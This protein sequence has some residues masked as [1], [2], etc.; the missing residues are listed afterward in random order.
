M[1]ARRLRWIVPAVL[2]LCACR[3][4]PP[5]AAP[6]APGAAPRRVVLLSLDGA[7]AGE[8]HRLY[9]AG[10]L[11]AGGFARFFREGQVADRLVP[12]DPSL[13]AVNHISLATGY[14]PGQTG[15]VGNHFHPPDIPFPRTVSGFA[16]PIATET[17]WEA[18]KRQ[19]KRVGV[20]TWP[21]ADD[22]DPRRRADWGMI[23]VNDPERPARLVT[24]E[25]GSW[26]PFQVRNIASRSP[27]LKAQAQVGTQAFDLLAVDRTDDGTV[28][29]DGIVVLQ[30]GTDG[31]ASPPLPVGKWA[32]VPCR[33]VPAAGAQARDTG[34]PVKLLEL[35]PGLASA[36]LYF[37]GLYPLQAYPP[38][39]AADLA[40]QGLTWPGPPDDASLSDT[41]AGKPGIDLA[42]W[43]Q[44]SDR[45]TRFFGDSLIAAVKRPD[46]DLM[47]GYVPVIDEAGHQLTLTDPRQPGFTPERRDE[48]AAARLQVWQAVDRELAR[49]LAALDLST[50]VVAVVSDH[51]MM[52]V[53][54]ALDANAFLRDEGLLA[55]DPRGNVQEQG[56]A[57]F[58]IGS[59]GA[60]QVYT[61]PG[62]TDL[63]AT[64]RTLF[65]GWTVGGE[66]PVEKIFTRE[67]AAAVGLAHPDSG[68]LVLFLREGYSFQDL[69]DRR[70]SAPAHTLGKHGYLNTHPEV[71][72]IYMALGAGIAPGSAG[73]MRNPEVAGRVADW[74]GIGKPRPK[75]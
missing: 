44:Q 27:A 67:E 55:F 20:T 12:V 26:Q 56:T 54:T 48:L 8:L 40:A 73:T 33:T 59:G 6:A 31:A 66:K 70:P 21:G 17:L 37:S 47:M 69:P 18:A 11:T 53:H 22:T 19:G 75:P 57:A 5:P 9:E 38:G 13:T 3:S 29:Y 60:L 1:R 10:A 46:W 62:R 4:S 42:T 52:P 51:G 72:A 15:I 34:C 41:W 16:A 43:S 25:R 32:D 7:G 35:D 36:R 74:L 65:A 39:F 14:P 28:N 24:L 45:F 23:Y 30:A 50:T 49:L 63:V 68:D 71:Q 58:A 61:A 2:A 64:L